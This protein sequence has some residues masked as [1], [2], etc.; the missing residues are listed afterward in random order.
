MRVG[1]SKVIPVS[2]RVL[3]ASNVPLRDEVA[4]GRLRRDLFYRLNV[5][6]IVIPPL[7]ERQNDIPVLFGLFVRECA[8]RDGD[9]VPGA[10]PAGFADR[11]RAHA[12]PGNVRELENAAE[13]FVVLARLM[14]GEKAASLVADSFGERTEAGAPY[15][16]TLEDIVRK[17]VGAVYD[18]EGGNVSRAA[19]RLGVDRQTLRKKLER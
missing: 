18:E 11:L 7:R 17:A 8:L 14:D 19:K 15:A 1:D 2:V 6:D 9:P 5:L 4:Q 10:L 3:A 13:K 16:G 12:W